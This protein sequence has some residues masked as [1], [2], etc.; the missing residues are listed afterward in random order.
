[1]LQPVTDGR[2]PTAILV[3]VLLGNPAH[4]YHPA[5]R[6]HERGSEDP[7]ALEDSF[8]VVPKGA[9]A[10]VTEVPLGFIEPSVYGMVVLD[11]AAPSFHRRQSVVIGLRHQVA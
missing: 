4:R 10:K 3:Y 6:V 2:N 1:L 5:R 11:G 7:L 9:M 8:G